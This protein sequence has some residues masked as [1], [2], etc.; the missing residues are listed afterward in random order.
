[1][2]SKITIILSL[3][4]VAFIFIN[5]S[6]LAFKDKVAPT[7]SIPDTYIVYEEG[8]DESIL[9]Q[10]VTAEDD[11]DGDISE[12]V[13]IYDIAILEDQTRAQVIYAVY[14][15]SYNLGKASRTVGY[16]PKEKKPET[17]AE[18]TKTDDDS[19]TTEKPEATDKNETSDKDKTEKEEDEKLPEGYEDVEFVS[20]GS[21]VIRL[22]THKVTI[23]VGD[24]FY[25]LD[26]VDDA[27]DL[28][29]DRSYLFRNINIDGFYDTETKGEYEISYYCIDS[30]ERESNVAKLML[31]VGEEENQ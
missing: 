17:P 24:D 9:L 4:V 13:R 16:A 30:D 28:E 15:D 2:K 14:D 25:P 5:A 23:D 1:M 21:P 20:D 19:Q 22:K 6:T 8:M 11:R 26:Y 3:F 31:I 18:E 10:G 29:D 7:I 12:R 27:T